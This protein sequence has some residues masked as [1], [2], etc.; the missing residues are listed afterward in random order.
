MDT[1]KRFLAANQAGFLFC[2]P[3]GPLPY[4]IYKVLIIIQ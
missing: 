1:Y 3:N 4:A 2:Y